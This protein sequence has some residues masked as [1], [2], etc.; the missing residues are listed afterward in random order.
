MQS[1]SCRLSSDRKPRDSFTLVEL[2]NVILIIAAMAAII[3]A[4]TVRVK[5]QTHAATDTG[6][7]RSIGI[8]LANIAQGIN[9]TIPHGNLAKDPVSCGLLYPGDA[10]LPATG[11]AHSLDRLQTPRTFVVFSTGIGQSEMGREST[12]MPDFSKMVIRDDANHLGDYMR[13]QYV[14]DVG[15]NVQTCYRVSRTGKMALYLFGNGQV[16]LLPML[17]MSCVS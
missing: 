14:A 7:F 6:K 8:A 5:D 9:G 17:V 11:G 15:N 3:F 16:V 12:R 2:L 13:T 4:V 10:R 1:A